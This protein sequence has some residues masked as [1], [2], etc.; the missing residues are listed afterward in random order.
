M[1]V[2]FGTLK[3]ALTGTVRYKSF[4]GSICV[5]LRRSA[6]KALC[7]SSALPPENAA[8][9]ERQ[10]EQEEHEVDGQSPLVAQVKA[11]DTLGDAQNQTADGRAFNRSHTAQH[12]NDEGFERVIL[13][14]AGEEIESG[15]Q[16]AA[17]NP[18]HHDAQSK[19]EALN[20]RDI[21]AHQGSDGGILRDRAQCLSGA[22]AHYELLQPDDQYSGDGKRQ[23]RCGVQSERT[24][25]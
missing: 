24:E 16:K 4:L 25:A 6:A 17:G 22:G 23:Q 9:L 21:D 14:H 10:D 15:K 12:Y 1:F 20:A 18:G 11:G 13:A 2:P 3:H 19:A 8:W 5:H 7:L